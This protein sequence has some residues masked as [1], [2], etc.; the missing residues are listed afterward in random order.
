MPSRIHP[1]GPNT[2]F[3]HKRDAER[4]A[5]QIDL[6]YEATNESTNRRDRCAER[7]ESLSVVAPPV[8]DAGDRSTPAGA[9][10]AGGDVPPRLGATWV[11]PRWDKQGDGYVF[12]QGYWQ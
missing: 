2:C 9:A 3:P 6:A 8:G 12:V 11:A 7:I 4:R 10:E 5:H 1:P